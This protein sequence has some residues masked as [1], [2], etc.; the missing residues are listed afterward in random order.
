MFVI[1]IV[2]SE[3]LIS[4]REVIPV[5]GSDMYE[6]IDRAYL[7][8]KDDFDYHRNEAE[9]DE[10]SL[11]EFSKLMI[12][13]FEDDDEFVLIQCDECHIQYEPTAWH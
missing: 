1:N 9:D 13:G 2:Y 4:G 8:Y 6:V 12:K 7:H 5:I 11:S 10:L 3:G